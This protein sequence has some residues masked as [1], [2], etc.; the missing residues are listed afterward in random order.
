MMTQ[1]NRWIKEKTGINISPDKQIIVDT[2]I[3]E[4]SRENRISAAQYMTLILTGKIDKD[5]FIEKITTPESYF[6][7]HKPAMFFVIEKIIKKIIQK[8]RTAR[9]L[10]LPCARGEE[11]YSL[12]MMLMDSG[13][14]L[15]RVDILG[16]DI[17][18]KWIRHAQKGIYNTYSLRKM[19]LGFKQRHFTPAPDNRLK[20]G[21]AVLGKIQFVQA[22]LFGLASSGI[23]PGFD[24]IFCQ[25]LLIYFDKPTIGRALQALDSILSPHGWLFVDITE[26][27]NVSFPF[28]RVEAGGS[29]AFKKA[30][31]TGVT[32]DVA[33]KNI[34]RPVPAADPYRKEVRPQPLMKRSPRWGTDKGLPRKNS[35]PA[36]R[37]APGK[38][39]QEAKEAYRDKN[40]QLARELFIKLVSHQSYKAKAYSGLASLYSDE[41]EDLEAL[42]NAEL[43]LTHMTTHKG[44]NRSEQI[45]A[46]SILAVI[47]YRKGLAEKAGEHFD[48]L[49]QMAPDHEVLKLLKKL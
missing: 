28:Q 8:N 17:S 26:V 35:M 23:F 34:K 3:Q 46:H 1:L 22:N 30:G 2:A 25:N 40:F 16:A 27:P 13:V 31:E 9:I 43:A 11:P 19:P 38:I 32:K 36:S 45:E 18:K 42:E 21:A 47:L 20:V 37:D 33:A 4:L 49:K 24:V 7:R 14:S 48:I 6:L 15:S 29:F 39:L 12:A 5:P 10:S 44:L 41:G